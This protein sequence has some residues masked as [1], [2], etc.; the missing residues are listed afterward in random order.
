MIV[1]GPF[2]GG[3][4]LVEAELCRKFG[5]SRTPLR[6][7]LKVLAGEGLI[8]LQPNRGAR[9]SELSAAE[10]VSLFAVVAELEALAASLTCKHI[11]PANLARLELLHREMLARR[12][13]ENLHQYFALNEQIH[14]AIVALSGNCVLA[15]THQRLL[16]R[17]RRGRFQALH[18]SGRWDTSIAEHEALMDALRRRKPAVAQ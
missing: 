18:M 8:E 17:A 3:H 12:T 5:V 10:T 16:A 2:A 7:A 14:N 6:E 15:S 11:S 1:E 9:V 4:R 13:E